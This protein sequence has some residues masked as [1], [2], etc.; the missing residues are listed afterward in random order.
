MKY[1]ILLI[2]VFSNLANSNGLDDKL[3]IIKK[4]YELTP[5][6]CNDIRSPNATANEIQLGEL[7]FTSKLLSG[8]K[9]IAC[10]DCHLEK[11][12]STDG[13]P[14]AVGVGGKGEGKE[15]LYDGVGTIVPRN[16]ISLTGIGNKKFTQFFWDGKVGE[17]KDKNIYSQLGMK[18]SHKF[19][20][21]LAVASVMPILERDELIGS[22]SMLNTNE[23]RRAV[24]GKLYQKRFDA[25]STIINK[26]F[27]NLDKENSDIKALLDKLGIEN[28]DLITI[29][30]F[31]SKFI[32]NEFKCSTSK[33]DKYLQGDSNLLS[34]PEK[35]GAIIF[36]GKGRCA[37]CHKGNF[38]S[39]NLF[40]SIGVYQGKFGPHSRHRDLGRGG[41]TYRFEDNYKFR[42]P[43]L[44]DVKNTAPYG[45][46]GMFDSL[47]GVVIQHF[48]PVY[49]LM[50]DKTINKFSSISPTLDSRDRVLSTIRIHKEEEL[51]DLIDFL[52][53]L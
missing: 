47:E 11:F 10:I 25:V 46:N 12:H 28:V 31:I 30:N 1:L 22:S 4:L 38:Y 6:Q 34:D 24:G 9:N 13:L 17:D 49:S 37:S 23:I 50:R 19:D 18:L 14:L 15:R 51:Q 29:G 48:N 43:T 44:V 52:T 3:N 21:T 36:Y 27:L 53:T 20:N 39:D 16:A 41:V 42:T 5:K 40:H 26:R 33:F 32:A 7:F 8:N 45:H 2:V 35:R